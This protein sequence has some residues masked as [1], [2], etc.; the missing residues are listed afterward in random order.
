MPD[1]PPMRPSMLRF[2]INYD[3]CIQGIALL[4]AKQ[5]RITQYYIGKVFFFADKEHLLDWGRPISGDQYVA[6]DHGPVPTVIYDMLKDDAGLPDEINE[7]LARWVTITPNGNKREVTVGDNQKRADYPALS[8]AEQETLLVALKRYGHMSF[9]ELRRITHD[10]RAY[11]D[12]WETG[13][14][15]ATMDYE[16]LI[17]DSFQDRPAFLEELK[18]RAAFE[19]A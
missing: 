17:P 4:A 10:E 19:R 6:M 2:R 11:K 8:Q 18:E 7:D 12:A 13:L 9:N 3:K 1:G 14:R 16:K 15:N 5:P